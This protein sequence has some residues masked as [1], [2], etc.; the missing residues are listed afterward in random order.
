MIV[1]RQVFYARTGY[2]EI[3]IVHRI[4]R[5]ARQ[6][7]AGHP[8][9]E[10]I[11]IECQ[12]S[13][14]LFMTQCEYNHVLFRHSYGTGEKVRYYTAYRQ[15]WRAGGNYPVNQTIGRF[16][17]FIVNRLPVR[18]TDANSRHTHQLSRPGESLP[19]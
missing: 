7:S 14:R 12:R 5:R 4:A 17:P 15:D 13:M 8:L 2:C 10:C 19:G 16:L 18:L 6:L 9:A 1:L 3:G 11:R